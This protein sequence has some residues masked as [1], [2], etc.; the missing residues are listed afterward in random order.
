METNDYRCTKYCKTLAGIEDRKASVVKLVKKD[1]PKAIDMH[2]YVSVNGSTHKSEF[3]KAYNYKCAYCGVS[4]DIIPYKMFEIDHFINQSSFTTKSD[5]GYIEN[6]ILA[7]YDC[8]RKKSDFVIP[9]ASDCD[10]YPDEDGITRTFIRNE[11]YYIQI[12]PD[13]LQNSTVIDFYNQLNMGSELHRLDYL[14]MSMIG[15][16]KKLSSNEN[17]ANKLGQAISL[18]Q[19]KRNRMFC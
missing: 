15:L 9:T 13:K 11:N 5:A 4:L 12:S 1:H 17:V 14:L 2:N 18:L 6:L 19:T 10:L 7:C 3:M 8:N 16:A